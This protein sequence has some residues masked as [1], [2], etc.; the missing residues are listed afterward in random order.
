MCMQVHAYMYANIQMYSSLPEAVIGMVV[1]MRSMGMAVRNGSTV[2]D[3]CTGPAPSTT[4][5]LVVWKLMTRTGRK[6]NLNM[7]TQSYES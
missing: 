4:T 1:M 5:E 2:M 6:A 3:T 7:E